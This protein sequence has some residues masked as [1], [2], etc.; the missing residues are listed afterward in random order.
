[1]TFEVYHGDCL[2][3]L[4]RLPDNSI[5]T[6]ITS[7]P[8]YG[9]RDYGTA[10]WVGGDPNCKHYRESK[11]SD[12]TI[13]GHKTMGELDHPVGD[14]IYKTVCPR[15]GAIRVDNQVGLE[16]TLWYLRCGVH[17]LWFNSIGT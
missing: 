8:Y 2:E 13:T 14:A 15:C 5:N 3:Q 11:K 16:E 4:K 17:G 10:K 6:C 1:M 7:P 9:L 12:K